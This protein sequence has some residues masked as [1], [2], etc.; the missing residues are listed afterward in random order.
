VEEKAFSEVCVLYQYPR[1]PAVYHGK[2]SE[3]SISDE[4]MRPG[5]L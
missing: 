4:T 3:T 2:K 5:T 1:E